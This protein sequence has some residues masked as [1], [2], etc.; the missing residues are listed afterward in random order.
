M[1]LNLEVGT[2][3]TIAIDIAPKNR[4]IPDYLMG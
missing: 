3:Y 4:Q 2:D 1:S